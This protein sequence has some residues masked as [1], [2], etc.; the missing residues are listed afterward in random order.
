MSIEE[1]MAKYKANKS[2]TT[3]AGSAKTSL[4]KMEVDSDDYCKCNFV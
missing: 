3:T 2:D 4:K 1:L